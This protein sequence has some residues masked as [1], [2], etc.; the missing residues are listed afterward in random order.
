MHRRAVRVLAIAAAVTAMNGGRPAAAEPVNIFGGVIAYSRENQA[1]MDLT[2]NDGWLSADFG[3]PGGESWTPPYACFPCTPSATLTPSVTENLQQSDTIGVGGVLMYRGVEY[4]LSSLRFTIDSDPVTLAASFDVGDSLAGSTL[5]QFV[6]H[7][8]VQGQTADGSS[9]I[10]LSL[11]GYGK[12]RI[13][14]L[15]DRNWY[16]SVYRFE[17]PAAVPEP[18]TMILLGSGLVAVARL[19]K[20]RV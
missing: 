4:F 6:L 19:R 13:G 2:L 5:A 18:A 16:D 10:G 9:S 17:N 15:S 14:V 20:R 8:L 11:L 7:G 3:D 12:A 1:S